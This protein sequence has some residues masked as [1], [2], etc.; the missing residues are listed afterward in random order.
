MTVPESVDFRAEVAALVPRRPTGEAVL[1][2]RPGSG[3]ALRRRAT[4]TRPG[5]DGWDE[6]TVPYGDADVLAEEICGFG[7]DVRV[8]DPPE[9]REGVIRRLQAVVGA[10]PATAGAS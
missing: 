9:V 7:P 6:L 3:V 1:C 2:A 5:P 8:V 10:A 4:A